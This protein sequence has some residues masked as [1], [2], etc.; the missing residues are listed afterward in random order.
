[1][2]KPYSELVKIDVSKFTDKRDGADY[3]NWAKCVDLLHENGA[4]KVY[5]TPLTTAS[6]SSLFCSDHEFTD[7]KGNVNRCYEIRIRVVI[8]DMEFEFQSPVMNGANPVKDNSMSQRAVWTA[9]TRAF[10]KAVAIHTGL[11]F[12]LWSQ[13]EYNDEKNTEEDLSKHSVMKIRE[14]IYVLA[15]ALIKRGLSKQEIAE[16]CGI[17][18]EEWE[19]IIKTYPIALHNIEAKMR[20]I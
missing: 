6:G 2:L 11:G 14:R 19:A 8:D 12:S 15:T 10:V 9:Q 5:F 13:N 16:A 20:K 18:L 1:M 7:S 4:E 3:L 17:S